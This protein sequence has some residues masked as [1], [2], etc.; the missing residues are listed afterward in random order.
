MLFVGSAT[1]NFVHVGLPYIRSR[2]HPRLSHM[3]KGWIINSEGWSKWHIYDTEHITLQLNRGLVSSMLSCVK[4]KCTTRL[5]LGLQLEN[6]KS[7]FR[8][9]VTEA[10]PHPRPRPVEGNKSSSFTPTGEHLDSKWVS[11]IF[12][13]TKKF[14]L[15]L[16]FQWTS[17]P[18]RLKSLLK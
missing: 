11:K 14:C 7:T 18:P 3:V 17:S 8:R 1:T 10:L 4:L 6:V 13:K 16:S 5:S 9:R 2:Q 12:Q 15:K